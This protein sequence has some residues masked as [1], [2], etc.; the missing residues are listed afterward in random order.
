LNILPI[1]TKE[2]KAKLARSDGSL[3]G[4]GNMMPTRRKHPPLTKNE[5]AS[6]RYSSSYW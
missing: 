2:K 3:K 1:S 4:V 6:C 5:M